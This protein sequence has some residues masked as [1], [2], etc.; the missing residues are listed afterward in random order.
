MALTRIQQRFIAC[1]T[2]TQEKIKKKKTVLE[3]GTRGVWGSRFVF[4]QYGC[5]LRDFCPRKTVNV[6]NKRRNFR[7]ATFSNLPLKKKK[8]ILQISL[9]FFLC[10]PKFVFKSG[11][12]TCS[13]VLQRYVHDLQ[14]VLI[15]KRPTPQKKNLILNAHAQFLLFSSTLRK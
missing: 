3:V 6:P 9:V 10:I 7:T 12:S 11:F 14:S 1:Y 8:T 5:D 15:K 4:N 2:V 13:S